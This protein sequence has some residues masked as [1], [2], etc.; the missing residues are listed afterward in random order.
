[1]DNNDIGLVVS[2]VI[3]HSTPSNLSDGESATGHVSLRECMLYFMCLVA[4]DEGS[5]RSQQKRKAAW[6]DPH[7]PKSDSSMGQP[8]GGGPKTRSTSGY[9]AGKAPD[10][11]AQP[12]PSS[13][14]NRRTHDYDQSLHDQ[15]Q[16]LSLGSSTHYDPGPIKV[17]ARDGNYWYKP[18]SNTVAQVEDSR[19][20]DGRLLVK[21]NG[22][23]RLA[24]VVNNDPDQDLS[25]KS[26]KKKWYQRTLAA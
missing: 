14:G 5:W 23:R 3:Y 15:L 4:Q 10:R 9:D 21:V 26:T 19:W 20:E 13:Y 18:S 2:R 12:G 11:S 17:K 22:Q 16:T 8:S 24:T 7:G 6:I 25:N 1:M